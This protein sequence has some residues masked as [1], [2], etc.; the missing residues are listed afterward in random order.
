MNK[1]T[2]LALE[3]VEMQPKK[4]TDGVRSLMQKQNGV[5]VSAITI[6]NEAGARAL[7]KPQGNY[8]TLELPDRLESPA[9]RETAREILSQQL[10]RMLPE[11]GTVLVVGLGN[12]NITPDA[13]GPKCVSLLFATRHI[14]GEVFSDP[15]RLG[16]CGPATAMLHRSMMPDGERGGISEVHPTGWHTARYPGLIEDDYLYN[17]SHL[18]AYA[19]TGQNA[20]PLNLITGT[21]H[22]NHVGMLSFELKVLQY[23]DDSDGRVL[24]R[25]TPY[26]KD[27][28]LVARGVEMEACSVEDYGAGVSFHVFVYNYEP[29]ITID[30][31]TGESRLMSD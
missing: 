25:V 16:R 12:E 26:F 23:L 19:M 2:D 7:G 6:F 29:G 3:N 9:T 17:R 5:R 31:R 24:Y 18:I 27:D 11:R 22:M 8:V 21:H 10:Q 4:Q 30:Y 14:T 28:E 20:N 15:D 13:L 1:R